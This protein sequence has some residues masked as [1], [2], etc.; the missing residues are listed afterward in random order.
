MNVP[1]HI[2]KYCAEEVKRQ[3]DHALAV[4]WMIEAWLEAQR[5]YA[6][7]LTDGQGD[8]RF[9]LTPD[10]VEHLGKYVQ[11]DE[12]RKGFR[13]HN[14]WVGNH[15][16]THPVM[17]RAEMDKLFTLERV[18]ELTADLLYYEFESIH[19]FGD[20]NGRTGKIIFNWRNG[21]LDDPTMPPNFWGCSNP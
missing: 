15:K 13:K 14:I 9:R 18:K 19:P 10:L 17:L 5:I 6:E 7:Y 12:N 16:G 8:P 20:G 3:G 2:I 1:M 4:L 21:T 11:R